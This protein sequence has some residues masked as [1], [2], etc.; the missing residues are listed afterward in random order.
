MCT[1]GL[2]NASGRFYCESTL[3]RPMFPTATK[4]LLQS[5]VSG[6]ESSRL[7]ETGS[8]NGHTEYSEGT[9]DAPSRLRHC[10]VPVPSLLPVFSRVSEP[11]LARLW[12]NGQRPVSRELSSEMKYWVQLRFP[13]WP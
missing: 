5:L 6:G 1:H 12:E 2:T 7:R 4:A 8:A 13:G 11:S 3:E 10:V 9:S